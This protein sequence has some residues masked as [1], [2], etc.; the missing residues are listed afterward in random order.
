MDTEELH[1]FEAFNKDYGFDDNNV[2]SPS[3]T[4][5]VNFTYSFFIFEIHSISVCFCASRQI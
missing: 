4:E 2:I 1:I 5:Q 3:S